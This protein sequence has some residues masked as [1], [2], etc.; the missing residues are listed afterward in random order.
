MTDWTAVAKRNSRSVQTTVGWI[1][2]DPGAIARYEAL[3][4]PEDSPG[5]SA[6]S[7]RVPHPWPRPG[8]PR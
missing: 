1:F 6:T 5:R 4:L 7:R 8:R 2:W 3:G